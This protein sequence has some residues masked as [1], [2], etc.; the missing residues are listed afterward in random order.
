MLNSTI[1]EESTLNNLI[2]TTETTKSVIN[3]I[4]GT[5]KK[6]ELVSSTV[7]TAVMSSQRTDTEVSSSD[8]LST[9]TEM[10]PGT[11]ETL[12]LSTSAG[13]S[14]T[15]YSP[16]VELQSTDTPIKSLDNSTLTE[17]TVSMTT[18]STI[19]TTTKNTLS[20]LTE[21]TSSSSFLLRSTTESTMTRKDSINT[22]S[23]EIPSNSTSTSSTMT[24]EASTMVHSTQNIQVL[25]SSSSSSLSTE[26]NDENISGVASE[27]TLTTSI[28]EDH[29]TT[30]E[31]TTFYNIDK[32]AESISSTEDTIQGKTTLSST[33]VSTIL[34]EDKYTKNRDL[35]ITTMST[36]FSH[37]FLQSTGDLLIQKITLTLI[38]LLT[39]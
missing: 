10:D 32:K 6:S 13:E 15:S 24:S 33:S 8:I 5:S 18:A 35:D 9:T 36:T 2:F 12:S 11:E 16:S 20:H 27:A 22:H 3:T 25:S 26:G 17:T 31:G 38:P 37:K 30:L 23:T 29:T 39:L 28:H 21:N 4:T 19:G 1:K 34:T 7:N 14:M